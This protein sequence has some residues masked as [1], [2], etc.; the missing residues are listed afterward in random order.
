MEEIAKS[1][2]AQGP[3]VAGAALVIWWLLQDKKA[4]QKKLDDT[5]KELQQQTEDCKKELLDTAEKRINEQKESAV[6]L[7]K[8]NERMGE[9]NRSLATAVNVLKSLRDS[10]APGMNTEND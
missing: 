4:M 7:E 9:S 2:A 6:K 1:L 8:A 5:T 10:D 3:L